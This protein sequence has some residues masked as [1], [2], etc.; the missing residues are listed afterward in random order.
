M[1][2]EVNKKS[3]VEDEREDRPFGRATEDLKGLTEFF[4]EDLG[5]KMDARDR[6][7]S[8]M[9]DAREFLETTGR[10]EGK[11]DRAS[12]TERWDSRLTNATSF[13]D[14]WGKGGYG[15]K[16]DGEES[17]TTDKNTPTARE[18][19]SPLVRKA[20]SAGPQRKA[21]PA[22][23]YDRMLPPTQKDPTYSSYVER[24]GTPAYVGRE[25]PSYNKP[26]VSFKKSGGPTRL[27]IRNNYSN[28]A[29]NSYKAPVIMA[30]PKTAYRV[31]K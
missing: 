17:G 9:R 1:M 11:G 3:M 13:R 30:K 7:L 28:A 25:A 20:L 15:W 12:F 31:R 16:K 23:R 4:S 24:Y 10:Y 14:K 2:V 5:A 8:F 29:V 27:P 26:A 19:Y 6:Y 21:L 18:P 22:A